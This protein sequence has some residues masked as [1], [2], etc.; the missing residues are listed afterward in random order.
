MNT[1]RMID[2]G[3]TVRDPLDGSYRVV[4]GVEGDTLIL[5]DGGVMD[6]SEPTE[7]WLPG[8]IEL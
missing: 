2:A 6:I 8:E 3:D 5:A 1:T 4:D 7:V